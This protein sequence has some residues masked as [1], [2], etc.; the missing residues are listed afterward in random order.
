MLAQGNKAGQAYLDKS[1]QL[2]P[3]LKSRYA[4][5]LATAKASHQKYTNKIEGKSTNQPVVVEKKG[6][7][8]TFGNYTCHQTIYN[9]ASSAGQSF[10]H[11]YK[12]Y[13][14][15]KSNGTYKWLDNGQ[16]GKYQYNSATGKITWLS[17]KLATM[18]IASSL[19]MRGEKTAQI[20][21]TIKGSYIWEC[22]CD[23]K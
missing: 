3:A 13:F 4:N 23:K 9:G 14:E 8:L 17:G 11:Q 2:A 16:T 6:G 12:G 1:I 19:F 5:D 7:A 20:T 10:T 15:L 21:L 18:K 22:G